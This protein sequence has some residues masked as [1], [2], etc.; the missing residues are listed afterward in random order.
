MEY[1]SSKTNVKKEK[2]QAG[3]MAQLA[4]TPVTKSD[5]LILIPNPHMVEGKKR[6]LKVVL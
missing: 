6:L 4:K 3:K 2:I 1:L 5:D